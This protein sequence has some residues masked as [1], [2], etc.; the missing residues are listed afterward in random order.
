MVLREKK[1]RDG[2][3]SRSRVLEML[4]SERRKRMGDHG[5]YIQ[6]ATLRF[7]DP[8]TPQ[9]QSWYGR[10][11]NGDGGSG[12]QSPKEGTVQSA[13]PEQTCRGLPVSDGCSLHSYIYSRLSDSLKPQP[14]M[15][16]LVEQVE[17]YRALAFS[18]GDDWGALLGGVKLLFASKRPSHVTRL[19][20]PSPRNGYISL[21]DENL[22][23]RRICDWPAFSLCTEMSGM[24]QG[25]WFSVAKEGT[26]QR[27]HI[28]KAVYSHTSARVHQPI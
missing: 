23:A 25:R 11:E 19:D 24:R 10:V 5:E 2:S 13:S 18:G 9:R 26:E 12:C 22:S 20:T 7:D 3:T 8:R 14:N 16:K 27:I 6:Q 15:F 28:G 1:E 4:D 21:H 17:D